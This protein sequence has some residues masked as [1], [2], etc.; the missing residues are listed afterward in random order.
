M[1][2][3]LGI[4]R[5]SPARVRLPTV[6]PSPGRWPLGGFARFFGRPDLDRHLHVARVGRVDVG[7]RIAPE[8]DQERDTFIEACLDR[9]RLDVFENEVDAKWLAGERPHSPDQLA[10]IGHA[11]T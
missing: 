2:A 8:K 3:Y 10:K 9:A 4:S 6:V 1:L 5:V 7:C 11:E